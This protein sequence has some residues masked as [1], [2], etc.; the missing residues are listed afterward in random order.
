MSP[1]L[2]GFVDIKD[3]AK[4]IFC[5]QLG[6]RY[7]ALSAEV[8]TSF[9]LGPALMIFDEAGQVRGPRSELF[10]AMETATAAQE[11]PL[12]IIISTQAPNDSDLLSVLIDDAQQEHDKRTVLRINTAPV[13]LDPFSEEAI[14][15]A[16]PAYDVFMNKQEVLA[17]AE[18]ARR[19]PAREASYRNLV[20]NQRIA[21][22]TRFV[23]PN[24]WKSC[25]W[26]PLPF[27]EQKVYAGLDLSAV[28]DL[29]AFV[30]MFQNKG[31]WQV[32]PTFWLPADNLHERA[33]TDR[34]PYDKW[35]EQGLIETAPGKSVDYEYVAMWLRGIFDRCDVQKVAFDRWNF[36]NLKAALLRNGFTEDK[37]TNH[38]V[39]F[40]QGYQ[41]MSPA[42]HI[43]ETELVN[44]RIAHGGH[45][46]LTMCADNA[47]V[48]T[49]PQNNRKLSKQKSVQ[50]IDG[51]VALTMA[52]GVANSEST[53]APTFE[54]F[55]LS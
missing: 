30:L 18:N 2:R 27:D 6:T 55:A 28:D 51:L 33:K 40:G 36:S 4:E 13:E 11:E 34:V 37:I 21:A 1:K 42:L 23:S 43:F 19:M 44:Q 7:K 16:N 53:K 17:M 46:V 45:P 29:T 9:G 39:E 47:A 26:K 3:T 49:D 22:E 52:F 32:H 35:A 31:I 20:L 54:M 14:R 41:S 25:N 50:R 38:F 24:V 8:S 15:L 5:Q 12:T 48:V 10:E